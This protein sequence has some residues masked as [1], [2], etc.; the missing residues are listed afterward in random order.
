MA[1]VV[2]GCVRTSDGDPVAVPT[3]EASSPAASATTTSNSVPDQPPLGITPTLQVP[4]PAGTVTCPADHR[5]PVSAVAEVPSAGAPRVTVG[6][7]EGWSFTKGSGDIGLELTGPDG[8]T[9]FVSIAPTELDPETAFRQYTDAMLDGAAV[10]S[11]SILPGERCD[12]SGQRLMGAR[13]E[14]PDDSTEFYVHLVHVWTNTANFLVAVDV[15]AP[16][17]VDGLDAANDVVTDGI[18][19]MIP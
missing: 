10:S 15:E 1:A 14:T 12:Y 19:I 4:I 5:P 7:P 16:T 2:T 13:S 11:V 6:I 9:G 3:G 17:G 8:M 18:E